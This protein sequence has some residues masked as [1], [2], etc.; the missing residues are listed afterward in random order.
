MLAALRLPSGAPV[1]ASVV[2]ML[3]LQRN[4]P[5]ARLR[6]PARAARRR[7]ESE[8]A[9]CRA[10]RPRHVLGGVE[11]PSSRYGDVAFSCGAGF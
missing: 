2:V 4:Q 3:R 8:F 9:S 5:D 6:R 1:R 10:P 11:P 7:R